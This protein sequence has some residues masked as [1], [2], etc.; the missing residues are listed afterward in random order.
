MNNN[1]YF[2]PQKS[3]D[4]ISNNTVINRGVFN[5]YCDD[6]VFPHFQESV[7]QMYKEGADITIAAGRVFLADD[8]VTLRHYL[9]TCEENVA[10]TFLM[11]EQLNPHACAELV[12]QG[13][14]S[15]T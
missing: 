2:T 14:V 7:E 5:N 10:L 6:F 3:S 8:G 12:G 11:L 4:I 9:F 1:K 15:V 13:E